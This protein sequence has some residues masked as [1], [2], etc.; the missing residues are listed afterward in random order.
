MRK[1]IFLIITVVSGILNTLHCQENLIPNINTIDQRLEGHSYLY[2][3]LGK[4]TMIVVRASNEYKILI[5]PD[6]TEVPEEYHVGNSQILDW[7]F[8]DLT[9]ELKHTTYLIEEDIYNPFFYELAYVNEDN[10]VEGLVSSMKIP[11][12][13][14][15]NEHLDELK[16]FLVKFWS[17]RY[18]IKK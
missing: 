18:F 2:Y 15:V 17:D 11:T 3:K 10:D 9:D 5:S 13:D 12:S 6:S 7:A 8:Q 16:K 1:L 4:V 14:K